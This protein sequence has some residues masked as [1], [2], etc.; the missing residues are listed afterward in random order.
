MKEIIMRE[1]TIETIINVIIDN[2]GTKTY[3]LSIKE[4]NFK[5]DPKDGDILRIGSEQPITLHVEKIVHKMY[6]ETSHTSILTKTQNWHLSSEDNEIIKK[7]M[8]Y[9]E[10]NDDQYEIR[11]ITN[12]FISDI[13]NKEIVAM[14]KYIRRELELCEK[15]FIVELMLYGQHGENF[16]SYDKFSPELGFR[17]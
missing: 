4:P 12:I 6:P 13:N 15:L 5:L 3:L 14:S 17:I 1:I 9:N 8:V 7:I 16:K 11:D 10:Y 2:K